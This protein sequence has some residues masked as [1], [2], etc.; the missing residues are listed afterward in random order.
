MVRR[1]IEANVLNRR[2]LHTGTKRRIVRASHT[3]YA[4]H[5]AAR[6]ISCGKPYSSALKT[7]F[8]TVPLVSMVRLLLR[9]WREALRGSCNKTG[10][11]GE[12]FSPKRLLK[13]KKLLKATESH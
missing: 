5:I 11:R 7:S 12:A 3:L 2:G 9:A 10:C 4:I 1:D 8:I 13:C 6:S